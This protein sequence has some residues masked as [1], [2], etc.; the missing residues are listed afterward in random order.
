MSTTE[1][2]ARPAR[3]GEF[4][5]AAVDLRE[6]LRLAF[7]VAVIQVGMMAM[8]AVDTVM[9]GRVSATD[10]AGV[11]IGNLYFF[12]VA[13]FG[14]GV[15]FALD[16]VVSQAVGADDRVGVARAVQR[17]I[18]IAA[19]L[20]VLATVLLLPAGP[21]LSAARQPAEVVPVAAGYAHAAIV[22]VFPFYA[23]VVLRQSLQAMGH[24]RPILV[25]IV[26]ANAFNI[27]M[28][29]I[30]VF[31]NLGV[32]AMGAIGSSWATSLSRW[33]MAL[34]LLR[35]SWVLLRPALVPLRREAVARK[36]LLRILGVGAPIGGQQFLEFGVFGASGLLMGWLGTIAV[37]SHQ[38]ALQLAALTFMVPVG[39]AQA[40]SVLV[41]Q[42]VGRADPPQARRAAG[43]GII[44]GAGFMVV[45]AALLLAFPFTFARWFSSDPAVVATAA[46]L[47]PIAGV[48]QVFDGLQVVSSGAL[49]GVA[50]TQVPMVL[51]LVG[52]WLVGLPISAWLGFGLGWGPAGIWWGL[53]LGIGV[54]A[55]LLAARV[56][57]RFGR[58]L[59][60]FVIDE[61]V[62]GV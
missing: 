53:A 40:T 34:L 49:R 48:F 22:G 59:R 13:V 46:L 5:P 21:A 56:R 41:G 33:F 7:P 8:G 47:L 10:L 4:R 28:N 30:F 20:T 45:T 1:L 11:A 3:I 27:F 35:S 38:V 32:P 60:R 44:V 55:I 19:A 36:P 16:P 6:L 14:M 54:V 9:V 2:P 51:T 42:A 12:G 57:T 23:F 29:W 52:F 50:D 17:G 39:V 25:T 15:L 43:A 18:V 58:A 37:A 24:V 31:G 26:A 61:A 62:E